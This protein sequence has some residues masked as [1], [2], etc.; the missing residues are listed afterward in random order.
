MTNETDERQT[1]SYLFKWLEKS[2]FFSGA[3]F[4]RQ[5]IEVTFWVGGRGTKKAALQMDSKMESP[6]ERDTNHFYARNAL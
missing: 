4:S 2:V 1:S 5:S 3:V 6:L